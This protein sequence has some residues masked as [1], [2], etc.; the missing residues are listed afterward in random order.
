MSFEKIIPFT[1]Q[2][3]GGAHVTTDP[4]DPGGTT[5]F[6]ISQRYHPDVDVANMTLQQ[7]MVI[8]RAGYWNHVAKGVDDNLD[9]VA[10][11]CAV[12]PGLGHVLNWL[13]NP[14]IQTW[15][16]LLEARRTYYKNKVIS[17]P[18]DQEYLHGWLNRCDDLNT[19]IQG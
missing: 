8:Y 19:F 3:E 12:N 1:L 5:K 9:M 16:D 18:K 7:A 10:F 4:N 6:G 2:H 15:Q 13:E 14:E 11:E 17:Q